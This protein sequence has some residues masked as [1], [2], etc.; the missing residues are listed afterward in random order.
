MTVDLNK[1]GQAAREASRQ[2]ALLG[3]QKKNQVLETVAQE[4]LAKA[5]E[6]IAANK[7]DLENATN[8]PEKFIDRLKIDNDRIAAMAEGVRQVAQLADPIGKIDAG[9]VNYAGLQIEKKRV[10]LGVVGMIFEARPNVTVDASALCF[11]SGNAVILRGGK[12]ALQTNIK[13]TKVIRQALEQEGINPDAVQVITE[14][15]HELANEFMQLTDYLD[16]LIPRGSA[17]LIQTVLNTA[18]VPVIETGAG[19]CHVYVDKFADKKMAVEITTNAKVQRPS[20]CNAI[21]NLVIH[22][23]VAQ[24]YLPAIADELQKY[25]VELRG[26]EKVCEILGDKATLAT[27]EDWD[28]EYNDYIIAIKIVSSIDEAIDFINEHNTKHSE[29]II[30][31]NYTRSQKFLDEI[32]AACVY[33]N[34][35]TRFTD[36]FEFGFGAEIGISTQKLHARGPM[37]LEALTSTKYVIRGNGQIRK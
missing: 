5:D 36:G 31:E 12:E 8:M 15:S 24:E 20:V 6:I 4:L 25:N 21:E 34:A 2:L 30:T 14:T 26:D 37:G 23:D 11:K 22:Q 28:T 18:K 1:M 13:I 33:V 16:V 10:P 17:R 19:I 35:S 9:W 7:V 32:D 29:A 3:E 27:A